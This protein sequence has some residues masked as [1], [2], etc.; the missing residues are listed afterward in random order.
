MSNKGLGKTVVTSV[1][2]IDGVPVDG[3]DPK[4]VRNGP[5]GACGLPGLVPFLS[6]SCAYKHLGLLKCADG[7]WKP[8]WAKLKKHF[9]AALARIRR[10]RSRNRDEIII[11][12]GALLGGLGGFSV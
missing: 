2:W 5:A 12:G 1:V 9:D 4:L 8:A 7:S 10:M 11:V 3:P 6:C